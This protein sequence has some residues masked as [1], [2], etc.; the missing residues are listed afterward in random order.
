VKTKIR[1]QLASR[2]SEIM[3]RLEPVRGGREP[4]GL[5]PEFAAR[6]VEYE[7]ADRTRAIASGGIGAI[8]MLA[9]KVGWVKA[10][11]ERLEILQRHR[12]Y[13]DSDHVRNIAF[14]ILCGG[15]VLDDIEVRRNDTAFL[16]ALGARTI[17]D[18]TT[19]GDFCRRFDAEAIHRL[20][21]II[22]DVRVRVWKRQPNSFFDGVARIDADGTLVP[23]AGECKQGMG[24]SY[25]GVWGYHPLVVSLSN[26]QEPLYIVNRSGNRPSE[27][28]APDYFA[29]AIELC[30]NAGWKQ[31][32]LRGDTAFM[33]TSHFDRW[34]SDGV[35]FVFGY[36]ALRSLVGR[37]ETLEDDAYRELVRTAEVAFDEARI[38]RTKQPRDEKSKSTGAVDSL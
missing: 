5:G 7:I 34:D 3:S 23:T 13:R 15:R 20:M 12:P 18:P 11:D 16:D 10:I 27:E 36:D 9:S 26:T 21:D 37:A 2:K 33:Q 6:G 1:R 17:P 32:L 30:R 25:N 28:G 24:L 14:N 38:E 35:R 4:L 19:A 22:N 8:L 31:I 29:R